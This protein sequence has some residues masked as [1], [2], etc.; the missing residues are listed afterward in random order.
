MDLDSLGDIIVGSINGGAVV[1]GWSAY[2]TALGKIV[3]TLAGDDF[4]RVVATDDV[5]GT[6]TDS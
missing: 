4:V 5:S 2:L 6:I 1:D 3:S